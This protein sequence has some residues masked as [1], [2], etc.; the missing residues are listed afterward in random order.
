MG[1][2]ERSRSEKIRR[3]KIKDELPNIRHIFSLL[4]KQRSRRKGDLLRIVLIIRREK[5]QNIEN[6]R[7]CRDSQRGKTANVGVTQTKPADF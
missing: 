6:E 2:T 3:H 4:N 1:E 5:K 7:I